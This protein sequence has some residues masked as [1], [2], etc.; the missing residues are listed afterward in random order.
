VTGLTMPGGDPDLLEQLAAQLQAIA[1]GTA[2]LGSSTRQ[3][4][5]SIR[6]A[7]EWTGAASDAY[8]AFTG[9]LAQG[10]VG[11]QAPL[12]R[13]ASAVRGYAGC[14]RTAQEKVAAYASAAE[15]AQVSG[16]DSGYLSV[17]KAAE[18]DATTAVAAWQAAGD[19]A[20]EQVTAAAGQLGDVFGAQGPVGTWLARQPMW[21]TLAG[22][23]GLGEPAGPEILKTPGWELGPQILKTPGAALGPQILI[24]PPGE[25]GPEILLT[26]P[27]DVGPEILK[28]PVG[29]PGPPINYD[30]QNPKTKEEIDEQAG[31]LG[32]NKKISPQKAPFN[33]HGMPVYTDGKEYITPDRDAHNVTSGW[34]VFNRRGQRTGTWNWDLTERVKN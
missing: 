24:T 5:S 2:D 32:Y 4:T 34:K 30:T 16:D 14:L 31:I 22:F 21:D 19:H 11:A 18:Q 33:S 27:G 8:T 12:S 13:I 25:L 1:E 23:P 9:D 7:A 3:V 17:A 20:A 10:V 28:T 29:E 15:A 6:S 26:P